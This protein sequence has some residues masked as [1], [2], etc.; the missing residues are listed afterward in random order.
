M[1]MSRVVSWTET[2]SLEINCSRLA[3]TAVETESEMMAWSESL[4]GRVQSDERVQN[5]T[6][7]KP[8][9]YNSEQER[10]KSSLKERP[11]Q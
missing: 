8:D 10:L 7:E 9:S 5:Q 4:R 6:P 11:E 3:V 2:W 1:N